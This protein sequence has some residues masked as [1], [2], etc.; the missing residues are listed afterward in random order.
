MRAP[1][2]KARGAL[3]QRTNVRPSGRNSTSGQSKKVRSPT[4]GQRGHNL[5][6][7]LSSSGT[8]GKATTAASK[9]GRSN[10]QQQDATTEGEK[11]KKKKLFKLNLKSELVD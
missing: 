8:G 3:P 1:G 5:G 10:Q 7:S 11:K 4:E 2:R 9:G 6:T